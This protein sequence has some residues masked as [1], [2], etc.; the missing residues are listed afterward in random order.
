MKAYRILFVTAVLL[1]ATLLLASCNE[2]GYVFDPDLDVIT[3]ENVDF[4]SPTASARDYTVNCVVDTA[5]GNVTQHVTDT[6]VICDVIVG[7]NSVFYG[8][9]TNDDFR[10][11]PLS[12]STTLSLS[13]S[14][15]KQIATNGTVTL[16]AHLSELYTIKYELNGGRFVGE[17]GP[18]TYVPDG[19]K[20]LPFNVEKDGASFAGWRI[21]T[22]GQIVNDLPQTLRGPVTLSAVWDDGTRTEC[23]FTGTVWK[24]DSEEFFED[25]ELYIAFAPDGTAEIFSGS[26]GE[27]L[28]NSGAMVAM[29]NKLQSLY[30]NGGTLNLK[31]VASNLSYDCDTPFYTYQVTDSGSAIITY[32]N[33][34]Y[35]KSNSPTSRLYSILAGTL[36]YQLTSDGDNAILSI[37]KPDTV[38][39]DGVTYTF[40][41]WT[42]YLM[43]LGEALFSIDPAAVTHT[44]GNSTDEILPL[45]KAYDNVT[46][47]EIDVFSA[48]DTPDKTYRIDDFYIFAEGECFVYVE[49]QNGDELSIAFM[50]NGKITVMRT[51]ADLIEILAF[52]SYVYEDDVK[53]TETDIN[54]EITLP[55]FYNE[56]L[57]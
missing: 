54:V 11:E 56:L 48:Y 41:S 12:R 35:D 22:T 1:L 53:I 33:K 34:A 37:Q 42:D 36:R 26:K 29:L 44:Y 38:Q 31:D 15:L 13:S 3:D 52:K 23:N 8:W 50:R 27:P 6:M 40:E 55:N 17:S 49:T 57:P 14:H 18:S 9:Y 39:F 30:P 20:E 24:L 28:V 25:L 5:L 21:S 4:N 2:E 10:G 47:L 7:R 32:N 51:Y 16:Y 43:S 46:D 45:V 19:T